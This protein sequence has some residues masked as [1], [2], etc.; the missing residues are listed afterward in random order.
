M[1]SNVLNQFLVRITFAQSSRLPFALPRMFILL[2]T[3]RSVVPE[4]VALTHSQYDDWSSQ[5]AG[6]LF[7]HKELSISM[8]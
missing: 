3:A 5:I 2:V 6:L 4:L 1:L 8:W 7:Y